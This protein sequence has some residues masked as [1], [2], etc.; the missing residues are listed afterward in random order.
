M[1]KKN[2]GII[3]II[4]V[5]IFIVIIGN[6]NKTNKKEDNKLKIV[7]SFYPMYI[8]TLNI[9]NGVQNVEVQNMAE[10]HKGCIHDY[11]L[12]TSDLKKFEEADIFIQNG[13]GIEKFVDKI[14]NSYPDVKVIE[15]AKNVTD[16][17]EDE[18]EINAHFWTSIDNYIL[19]V[20]E[21]SNSL[22][23]MDKANSNIYEENANKYIGK[24]K[25]IKLDYQEK[26]A[27]LKGKKVVSLNEAFS[28][29]FKSL[30]IDE[31]LIETDHEN[32]S[33]SAEIVK[34]IINKIKSENIECI[35][36]G[37]DDD[38]QNALTI[39]NETNAK[40]YRLKDGMSGDNSLDSYINIMNE[41][42]DI[43][44]EMKGI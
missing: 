37:E 17:I 8:M 32:N 16:I 14:L 41:N 26:L 36:I 15:S 29:L 2:I 23:E 43:L 34:E 28:Y 39:Q 3:A 20:K 22:K 5:L 7:T 38:N 30:E 6:I 1:N 10:F 24:L 13:Q 4:I 44:L 40:I 19:Q 18:D 9:T 35:V 21:I 25:E 11:T 33:L 12:M 31:T 27:E 42:L